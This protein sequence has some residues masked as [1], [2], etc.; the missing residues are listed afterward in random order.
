MVTTAMPKSFLVVV[1]SYVLVPSRLPAARLG[2]RTAGRATRHTPVNER[3]THA[4]GRHANSAQHETGP[5]N[6][7]SG[8]GSAH[9]IEQSEPDPPH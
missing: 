9:E 3:Q 1:S 8:G 2:E 7:S 4:G 6:Q 5:C